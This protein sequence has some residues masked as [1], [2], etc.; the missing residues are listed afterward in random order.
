MFY[1]CFVSFICELVL[2]AIPKIV[3]YIGQPL[4]RVGILHITT[5]VKP[6]RVAMVS[7]EG[8]QYNSIRCPMV[9]ATGM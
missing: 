7:T 3:E 9:W 2:S 4:F 8:T 5:R 1:S 6:T